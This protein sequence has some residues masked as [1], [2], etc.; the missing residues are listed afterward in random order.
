MPENMPSIF[1]DVIGP[2]MRG[3]SSSHVVAAY[4]MG[5]LLYQS[6]QGDVAAV[7]VTVDKKSS[8]AS[9]YYGHGS[10][11]G[12]ISGLLDLQI[13]DEQ[14]MNAETLLKQKNISVS[15]AV[16]N[17]GLRHPNHYHISAKSQAGVEH[18]WDGIST[19]GGMLE[20][21]MLDGNDISIKGD[22]Y[23]L[24]VFCKSQT[25]Q[26][27]MA[28]VDKMIAHKQMRLLSGAQSTIIQ[29]Q[30]SV[31]IDKEVR[32]NLQISDAV[33]QLFYLE[34]VLPIVSQES[35]SISFD[36]AQSLQEAC[37][38]EQKKLCQMAQQYES[39]RGGIGKDAVHD[40]MSEIVSI[41]RGSS[42]KGLTLTEIKNS[43][44]PHQSHLIERGM[45][46]SLLVPNSLIN[47]IIKQV[48][49]IM[50]AKSGMEIIVAAPTAGS[51][52]CLPGTLL[53]LEETYGFSHEAVTNAMLTAG[54]VGVIIAKRATFAAEVAGCQVECGAG[55]SMAAAAVA[56]L[57]GGTVSQC[58]AAASIAFQNVTG[59]ACD[60]VASRV[61]VPCLGKNIMCAVNAVAAA[62]M[63]L[64][65]FEQ[66]IPLDE[67]I[68]AIYD[69][70]LKIPTELRCTCGGLGKTPTS[71][72][73][74]QRLNG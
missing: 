13:T 56:E 59:L 49:A 26:D 8:L 2:V 57:F 32:S 6:M 23:E 74:N 46:T 55:S 30:T 40:K 15:F 54:L 17:I 71:I 68:D 27:M 34:P 51:C 62:S 31:E 72:Q 47:N 3:A 64:A 36:S 18:V 44:L 28:L 11:L 19:G 21:T 39:Q 1:N 61:E 52:G 12:L 14:V 10:H 29:V 38:I 41:M 20:M 24:L 53:A 43:I 48:T 16:C 65:G 69:I 42:Q 67:T 66:V 50:E 73:L 7:T 9:T 35:Y 25:E 4:R 63:A 5:K 70:G 37:A 33:T 22:Y 60:P 58:L 45:Q